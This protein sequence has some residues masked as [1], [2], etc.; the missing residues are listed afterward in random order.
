MTGRYRL[1][2]AGYKCHDSQVVVTLV[3]FLRC[4]QRGHS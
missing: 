4:N 3:N 2:A 1:R